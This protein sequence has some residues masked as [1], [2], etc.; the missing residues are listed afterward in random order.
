M[1]HTFNSVTG[2]C[3]ALGLEPSCSGEQVNSFDSLQCNAPPP[4]S[5]PPS[6]SNLVVS[7]RHGLPINLFIVS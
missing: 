7:T 4:A 6:V 2:V 3:Q 5:T 1:F